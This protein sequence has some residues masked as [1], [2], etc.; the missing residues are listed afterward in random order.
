MTDKQRSAARTPDAL[1]NAWERRTLLVKEG[2]AA[3][4]AANDAKT[5]RLKALRLERERQEAD[6]G[7][8][9]AGPVELAREYKRVKPII[10]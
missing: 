1:A 9:P 3:A 7:S 5:A 8:E 6:V 2:L 4:S 10:A